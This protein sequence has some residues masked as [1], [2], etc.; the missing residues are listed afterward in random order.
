MGWTWCDGHYLSLVYLCTILFAE[1]FTAN[2]EWARVIAMVSKYTTFALIVLIVY[3]APVF[4][5][6]G[7][8]YAANINATITTG[9]F[10]PLAPLNLAV[11][12]SDQRVY[13]SWSP[14]SSDGGSS[15][16]DYVIEYQLSSGGMWAI[17]SDGIS[18]NST[19]TVTGLANDTSYDFRVSAINAIGQG[20]SSTEV[21]A[22][23]GAP[24]QVLIMSMSDTSVPSIVASVRITNEGISDYEYQYSWCVTNSD[25]NL[26]GGGDDI[27]GA[28][29]AK[30]IHPGE[31]WNT[32]LSST[33]SS[34]G[35]Y[36]FHIAVDF[37]SDSS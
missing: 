20:A 30:L 36:W 35:N 13:L 3:I 15:I 27:S 16:I 21:T 6:L 32:D 26:C 23:P 29:A 19:T 4:T 11:S 34:T 18:A 5:Y 7:N 33:V 17:F 10:I 9:L 22:T 31:N 25:V 28:S 24:A 1:Y 14:P 37:G 8:I 2:K 12:I